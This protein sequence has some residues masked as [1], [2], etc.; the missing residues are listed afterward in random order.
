MPWDWYVVNSSSGREGQKVR[1]VE[2]TGKTPMQSKWTEQGP[3][4]VWKGWWKLGRR[5]VLAENTEARAKD[6]AFPSL[7]R[8]LLSLE[9]RRAQTARRDH[10][11]GPD[12]A[13]WVRH[14]H[15]VC[16]TTY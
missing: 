13:P 7:F 16:N 6:S 11:N 3:F 9:G 5:T 1:R 15:H 8:F 14:L 2:T 10:L 12:G 4:G